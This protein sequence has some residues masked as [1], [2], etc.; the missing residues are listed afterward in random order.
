MDEIR[1]TLKI[2]RDLLKKVKDVAFD[3]NLTQ[4]DLMIN[5]LEYCLENEVEVK[6]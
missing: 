3:N 2:D 4:N 1:T 5:Y 6:K